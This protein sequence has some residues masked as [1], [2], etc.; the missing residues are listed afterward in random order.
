MSNEVRDWVVLCISLYSL[1]T[2]YDIAVV[3]I[4]LESGAKQFQSAWPIFAG[5]V[6]GQSCV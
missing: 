3:G 6:F 2:L 4:L 5:I 1:G